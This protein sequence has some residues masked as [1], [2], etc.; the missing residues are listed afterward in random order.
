MSTS[1]PSETH[2]PAP[3]S[4]RGRFFEDLAPGDVFRSRLGR[5]VTATDNAWFTMLTL[6]T[7]QLHFNDAQAERSRWGRQ[8][9]NSCLTLSIVSG[10]SVPDTSE[11]AVANLSWSDIRLPS[12]VFPGDT[13]WA[14]TEILATRESRTK[15]DVGIVEMR[16]RGLNQRGEVVI[17]FLRAFMLPKRAAADA[18]FPPTEEPWHVGE[19]RR[20]G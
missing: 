11:N 10:L 20:E 7:N 6:N 9:V 16:T 17:E 14:E 5:T 15:P 8:L 1:G 2:A 12:P 4:W 3:K 19:E 13:L 18:F